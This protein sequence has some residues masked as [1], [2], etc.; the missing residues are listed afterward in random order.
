VSPLHRPGRSTRVSVVAPT[1]TAIDIHETLARKR[2]MIDQIMGD[3]APA[4]TYAEVR[5]LAS[6]RRT[7]RITF[8]YATRMG[9]VDIVYRDRVVKR[10]TDG[11]WEEDGLLGAELRAAYY[12]MTHGLGISRTDVP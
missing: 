5:A 4:L 6:P 3:A 7:A 9:R 10:V 8:D 12:A 1:F 2:A 11:D